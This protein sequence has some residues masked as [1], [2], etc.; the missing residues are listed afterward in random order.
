MFIVSAED[1]LR[2]QVRELMMDLQAL[3]RMKVSITTDP[4]GTFGEATI[5]G[6]L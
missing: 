4:S 5:L 1:L 2:T 3:L 6:S